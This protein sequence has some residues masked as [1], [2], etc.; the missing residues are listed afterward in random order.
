MDHGTVTSPPRREYP[1][2]IFVDDRQYLDD[3]GL[4]QF[5]GFLPRLRCFQRVRRRFDLEVPATGLLVALVLGLEDGQDQIL[6]E[7]RRIGRSED[8][9]ESRQT[10]QARQFGVVGPK[11]FGRQ[12][13]HLRTSVSFDIHLQTFIDPTTSSRRHL[14]LIPAGVKDQN[15]D[16]TALAQ[17]H[18]AG[19]EFT[20]PVADR[21]G[22][23]RLGHLHIV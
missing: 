3:A 17:I 2:A 16:K 12:R 21:G 18:R 1:V 7:P 15:Q 10:S 11:P 19:E 9:V 13:A 20:R 6:S 4:L 5:R 22:K 23:R 8:G 14:L